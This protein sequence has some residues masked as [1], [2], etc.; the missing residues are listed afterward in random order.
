MTEVM[1]NKACFFSW[2]TI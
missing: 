2:F 1:T